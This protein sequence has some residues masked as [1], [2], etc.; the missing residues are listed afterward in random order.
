MTL[1]NKVLPGDEFKDR[2]LQPIIDGKVRSSF[3]MTEPSPGSGSDPGGMMLTRAERR[4]D[5]YVVRGRKWFI[6]GAE[7]AG[8]FILQ[9]LAC[10]GMQRQRIA[11]LGL[12][13]FRVG[14][15][16]FVHLLVLRL[17]SHS[18]LY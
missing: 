12:A 17:G 15:Q 14:L 2:W 11:R 16:Q 4:G 13:L 1:L 8:H 10:S 18:S 9:Q 5:R 7:G 6:T 3:V